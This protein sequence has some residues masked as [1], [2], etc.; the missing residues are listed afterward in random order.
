MRIIQPGR[1]NNE[2]G[3]CVGIGYCFYLDYRCLGKSGYSGFYMLG[4]LS[5]RNTLFIE[6]EEMKVM[7]LGKAEDKSESVSLYDKTHSKLIILRYSFDELEKLIEK[8]GK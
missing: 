1:R 3:F 2:L 4:N 6:G 7:E 8:E 5:A